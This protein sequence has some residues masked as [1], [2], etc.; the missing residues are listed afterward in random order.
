MTAHDRALPVESDKPP[1]LVTAA[2]AG[3]DTTP[4]LTLITSPEPVSVCIP[5]PIFLVRR[6]ADNSQMARF[7]ATAH[8]VAKKMIHDSIPQPPGIQGPPNNPRYPQ[9]MNGVTR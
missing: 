2:S 3:S 4:R 7:P 5:S 1:R 8:L 9:T 6:L